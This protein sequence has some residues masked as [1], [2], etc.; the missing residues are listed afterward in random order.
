MSGTLAVELTEVAEVVERV[1]KTPQRST[2]VNVCS[3]AS[4][5]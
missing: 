4:E 3:G 5:A 1:G 2:R